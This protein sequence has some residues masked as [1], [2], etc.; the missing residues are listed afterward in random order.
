MLFDSWGRK[1]VY[2]FTADS[3]AVLGL[4]TAMNSKLNPVRAN[5]AIIQGVK[6]IMSAK[7]NLIVGASIFTASL[8]ISNAHL[9]GNTIH[10]WLGVSFAAR[11]SPTCF[12]TGTGS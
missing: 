12:C 2:A 9:T 5:S 6:K 1:T 8:V 10:E 11:S 3:Q 4:L 7:T